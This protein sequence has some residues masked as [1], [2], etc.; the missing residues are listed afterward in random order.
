M[1][2]RAYGRRRNIWEGQ[3]IGNRDIPRARG[4]RR[5]QLDLGLRL[6]RN[7]DASRTMALLTS[8]IILEVNRVLPVLVIRVVVAVKARACSHEARA[9]LGG[10]EQSLERG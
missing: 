6:V 5:S 2:L 1:A 9:L 3:D 10:R 7:V 8:N 4:A